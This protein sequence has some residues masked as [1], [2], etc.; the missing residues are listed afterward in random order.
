MYSVLWERVSHSLNWPQTLHVSQDDLKILIFLPSTP[1]VLELQ[2]CTNIPGLLSP[3]SMLSSLDMEEW[4]S[5]YSPEE[6]GVVAHTWPQHLR[7]EAG[8]P[9]IH[10]HPYLRSQP[11]LAGAT[12][13]PISKINKQERRNERFPSQHRM[14]SKH[15]DSCVYAEGLLDKWN[16]YPKN[17]A[18][19]V[20]LWRMSFLFFLSLPLI[21]P[22]LPFSHLLPA[23]FSSLLQHE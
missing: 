8:G 21:S 23:F 22:S 20:L 17:Q 9:D 15:F 4:G 11:R 6:A 10:S 1:K 5:G 16:W 12:A 3:F 19:C 14:Y 13:D 7:E 18:L 2:P